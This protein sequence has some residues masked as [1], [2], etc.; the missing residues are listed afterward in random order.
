MLTLLAPTQFSSLLKARQHSGDPG[1]GREQVLCSPDPTGEPCFLLF[2]KTSNTN[3]SSLWLPGFR[4]ALSGQCSQLCLWPQPCECSRCSKTPFAWVFCA[5]GSTC[6][7]WRSFPQSIHPSWHH[8]HCRYQVLHHDVR[9]AFG[10]FL[11][12]GLQEECI[13]WGWFP[14]HRCVVSRATFLFSAQ[15]GVCSSFSGH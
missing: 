12:S 15:E 5:L 14:H 3:S 8:Q 13:M 7:F 11:P 10:L 1:E 6:C 2:P 9:L 4:P